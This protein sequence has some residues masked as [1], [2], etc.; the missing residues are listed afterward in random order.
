MSGEGEDMEGSMGWDDT[1][2]I[3][4]SLGKQ[5]FSDILLFSFSPSP[6]LGK[7]PLPKDIWRA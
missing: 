6:G 7:V 5:D 4:Q 2:E 3:N 1:R